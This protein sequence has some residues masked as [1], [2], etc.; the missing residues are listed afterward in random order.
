[1]KIFLLAFLLQSGSDDADRQINEEIASERMKV[2]AE[3]EKLKQ[4]AWARA[5]Y[6]KIL[7]LD[8]DRTE[9]NARL[10]GP[11]ALPRSNQGKGS[12]L[13]AKREE[14]L[15]SVA[16][17]AAAKLRIRAK[18]LAEGEREL[19]ARVAWRRVLLYAPG[20]P[21]ARLA[22]KVTGKGAESLD[23][24]WGG[25]RS[26]EDL[27]SKADA[28]RPSDE[29]SVIDRKWGGKNPKQ[30]TANLRLEGVGLPADRLAMIARIAEADIAFM[31]QALGEPVVPQVNRLVFIIGEKTFHRYVDDFIDGKPE[32][33]NRYKE[34]GGHT[35]AG[36]KV[37]VMWC[38]PKMDAWFDLVVAHKATEFMLPGWSPAWFH[39]GAANFVT[40]LLT[41]KLGA[42]CMALREG[43]DASQGTWGEVKAVDTALRD[44]V[45]EGSDDEIETLLNAKLLT[46]TSSQLAKSMSLVRFLI[47][48]HPTYF[49]ALVRTFSEEVK[50]PRREV[51]KALGF[52]LEEWDEFWRRWYLGK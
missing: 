17:K 31:R 33:K 29:A 11:Q 22:L 2:A 35:D 40:Q 26:W 5:E 14:L 41:K 10:N 3:L 45:L 50:M 52:S 6:L 21:D 32:E 18:A 48:R 23:A 37:H 7:R 49:R 42:G 8:P 12:H 25:P 13:P 47:F 51:E 15:N 36:R 9:A 44:K 43:T 16:T 20:D 34:T 30:V 38:H 1:M 39:E 19:E 27:V 46:M 4:F 28:G 24:A